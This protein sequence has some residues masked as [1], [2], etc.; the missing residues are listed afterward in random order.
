M[1]KTIVRK[2]VKVN[3]TNNN[4]NVEFSSTRHCTQGLCNRELSHLERVTNRACSK[5]V[6]S[7]KK[8]KKKRKKKTEKKTKKKEEKGKGKRQLVVE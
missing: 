5:F 7:E 1:R 4:S 6:S 3:V 8:E 2:P